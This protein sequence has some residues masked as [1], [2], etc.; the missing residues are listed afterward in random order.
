[1]AGHARLTAITL[2]KALGG[3]PPFLVKTGG[4]ELLSQAS[5]P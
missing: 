3:L 2:G 1:M 4:D 5:A